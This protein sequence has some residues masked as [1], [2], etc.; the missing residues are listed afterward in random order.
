MPTCCRRAS[1]AS[2]AEFDLGR[3]GE[4]RLADNRGGKEEHLYPGAGTIDFKA[5]FDQIEGAGYR[6]H[7]MLAFG[8]IEDMLRGRDELVAIAGRG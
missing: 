8:T 6:G 4:V 1:R 2:P 3:C 5:M 7:Y